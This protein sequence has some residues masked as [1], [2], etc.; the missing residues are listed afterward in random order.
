MKFRDRV[1]LVTGASSG[2]GRA[3]ALA[4]GASGAQVGLVARRRERLEEVAAEIGPA[5]LV[6]PG[7]VTDDGFCASAVAALVARHGR[8]DVAIA[9]AGLSMNAPFEKTDPDVFRRLLD[10]NYFG[11]LHAARHALPYLEQSHGSL[12]FISSVVGKRGFPTR[13]GYAAAKFA[14]HGLFESLRAELAGR[15]VHVGI[16]CPGFTQTE[17]RETALGADGRQRSEAGPTTGR[18]MSSEQAAD[19]ILRAIVRRRREV[20]LTPEGKLMVL[21][22]R[23]LPGLADR[24]AARAVA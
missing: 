8:L 21:L 14:V 10:V 5:A 13:S 17:I 3:L 9:N 6:L 18:V 23:L 1:V 19:G 15:G 2:I 20:V 7:D 4:L 11:A 12:V 16:V 22:N 24:V